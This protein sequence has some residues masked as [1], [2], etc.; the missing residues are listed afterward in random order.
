MSWNQVFWAQKWGAYPHHSW[1][2]TVINILGNF[3]LKQ[4]SQT[5]SHLVFC[6][7]K[8]STFPGFH[9][10]PLKCQHDLGHNW[11]RIFITSHVLLQIEI[12]RQVF[13]ST[14]W[15]T[16]FKISISDLP[17]DLP[18]YKLDGLS[19]MLNSSLI[20]Y[21]AKRQSFI[22]FLKLLF[23]YSSSAVIDIRIQMIS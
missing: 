5:Q 20:Y 9:L 12:L 2:S 14:I 15:T 17:A 18:S 16:D 19:G 13:L 7:F 1:I 8:V 21:M 4:S 23:P 6:G 3:F 22:S 11:H 10:L